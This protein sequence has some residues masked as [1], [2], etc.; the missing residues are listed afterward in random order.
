VSHQH[1]CDVGEHC[2]NCDGR[3]V[4]PGD[5]EP[6]TCLCLP[7]G[8]PL[9]GL[10]HSSC[11]G[12]VEIVACPQHHEE[13]MRRLA[14]AREIFRRRAAEFGLSEKCERMESMPEGTEKDALTQEIKKWILRAFDHHQ[15]EV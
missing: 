14:V 3:A 12:P 7:C 2:W 9:E 10:D 11:D 8:R 4:H 15:P 1:F 6:S 13:A 5:T